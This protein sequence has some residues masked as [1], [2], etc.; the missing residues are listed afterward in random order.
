MLV[1]GCDGSWPGPGGAGSGYL[2]RSATTTVLLDA[3]PGTMANL[4]QF[5]DPATVDAVV[6]SHEHPDHWTDLYGFDLYSQ[7]VSDRTGTPVLAPAGLQ[8]RAAMSTSSALAWHR[9]RHGDKAT[10]GDLTCSFFRTDHRP[11]TLAVRIDG[12]GRSLGYS[13]DSGPDWS[14]G[15]LGLGLDL[16]LC[17]ATFTSEHEGVAGHMSARQAGM[18]A[19]SADAHR[20]VLTHRWPTI[21]A[22][23]VAAEAAEAFGAPVEQAEIGKEWML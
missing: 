17:E 9:V 12:G 11:E 1:L 7:H 14:L 4:Q 18:Q 10:I 16:V 3:G 8:R 22:G 13:A 19:R 6:V 23:A 15:E 5:A 20:V 21:E 2:V